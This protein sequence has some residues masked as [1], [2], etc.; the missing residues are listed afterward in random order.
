V[1]SLRLFG[2]RVRRMLVASLVLPLA[3]TFVVLPA[4]AQPT[5]ATAT[6]TFTD[7]GD[8]TVTVTY[9]W[10]GFKGQVFL[11]EYAVVWPGPVGGTQFALLF[12]V[13]D[14]TGSGTSSHTFDL[15]GLGSNTYSG[16]GLLINKQGKTI[17]GSDVTSSTSATLSC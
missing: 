9:T 13:H 16:E 14:V 2:T 17:S 12:N 8:C 4:N 7:N 3:L 1:H 5:P 6:A 10:S 15:T 11:A